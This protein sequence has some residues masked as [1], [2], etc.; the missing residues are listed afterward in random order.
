[1]VKGA[2]RV[3]VVLELLEVDLVVDDLLV[4]VLHHDWFPGELDLRV[5]DEQGVEVGDRIRK[6]V[7]ACSKKNVFVKRWKGW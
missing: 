3:R 5:A 1:V 2:A 4:L 6:F 7:G